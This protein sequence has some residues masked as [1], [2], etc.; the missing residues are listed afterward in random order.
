[1]IWDAIVVG[2]GPAGS[3]AASFLARKGLQVLILEKAA[4]PPPKVCGEYLSPG[5]LRLQFPRPPLERG[6]FRTV[7]HQEQGCTLMD[8]QKSGK[9][10]QQIA[11]PF[12]GR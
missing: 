4:S 7:A 2:A 5:C 11:M 3:A 9:G 8:G 10:I 1:M 12:L 6:A